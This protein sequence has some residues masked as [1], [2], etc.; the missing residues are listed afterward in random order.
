M[1]EPVTAPAPQ[2][3]KPPP[4]GPVPTNGLMYSAVGGAFATVA[5]GIASSFGHPMSPEV[6]AATATLVVVLI[7]YLHPDGLQF[8]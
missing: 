6:A 7:S 8:K 1:D 2:L 4:S 5:S 3:D